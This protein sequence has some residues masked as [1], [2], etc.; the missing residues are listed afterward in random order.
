MR[1]FHLFIEQE[2]FDRLKRDAKDHGFT[3]ISSFVRFIIIK[4]FDK[5]KQ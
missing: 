1:R 2:W 4:F 3:T 5:K